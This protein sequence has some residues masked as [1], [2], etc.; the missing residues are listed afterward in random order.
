ME[1]CIESITDPRSSLAFGRNADDYLAQMPEGRHGVQRER[2]H[3]S[4]S[5]L[6]LWLE[7]P[8]LGDEISDVSPEDEHDD[9]LPDYAESQAQ[10][11]AH[12]RVEAAR[13]AQELQNRWQQ[14]GARRGI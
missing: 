3:T 1:A 2:L 7:P 13:R 8:R 14:S 12:Q 4:H 5:G 6:D 11:Q 9:E 10:A